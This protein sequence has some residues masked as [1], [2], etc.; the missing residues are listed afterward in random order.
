[1]SHQ[2]LGGLEPRIVWT[3]FEQI[4][5]IPRCSGKEEKIRG[6]V[7]EWADARAIDRRQ[8]AAGNLLLRSPASPGCE[9]LP[10]L[11]L[12]AH[13]DMVC[14]KATGS[15]VDF[16]RDPIPVYVDDGWVR[17]RGT[18]LGA[19][20][21]V[22]IALA[23]AALSDPQLRHGPLEVLLTV[24]EEGG[25][26]GAFGLEAG[27]LAGRYLVNLDSE[28]LGL[29]TIGTAGGEYTDF[30][31]PVRREPVPGW[32]SLRLVVD[33]LA[34]G[35]S[36]IDI[37][38]PRLN[39]IKLLLAGIEAARGTAELRIASLEG[40]DAAN[41][42]PPSARCTFLVPETSS[43]AVSAALAEWRHRAIEEAPSEESNMTVEIAVGEA[44]GDAPGA[45]NVSAPPCTQESTGNLCGLLA[46]IPHG[47]L[48]WSADIEGLVETSV[49]LARVRGEADCFEILTNARSS[50]DA[51]LEQVGRRLRESGQKRGARVKQHTRYPAW[52]ANPRSRF[53]LYVKDR[54][55]TVLGAE[56]QLKAY[57]AGLECGVFK[58]VAPELEMVSLGP[59][60]LGVH[61]PGEAIDVG[62]V[63]VLWRVLREIVQGMDRVEETR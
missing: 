22:G 33:G 29:I 31:L 30:S 18:T 36:G 45:P 4:T 2:T 35:H 38:L 21:G 53:N 17:A 50:V 57:H 15:R 12:Q 48:A 14:A 44:Q 41:V 34:G 63:R 49:N 32:V 39:A 61:G 7:L 25:M 58:G 1:M 26:K 52:K 5:R 62:S 37:H 8:D 6:W 23:L 3:L 40:G 16:E 10:T 11:I 9:G 19:D 43:G 56:V 24:D 55:E 51:S 42:I 59:T 13:L 20:N 46:E 27:F 47:V 60:L 28:E 54:Y